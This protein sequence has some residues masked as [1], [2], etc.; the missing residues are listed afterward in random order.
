MYASDYDD[1]YP[2][3]KD[4]AD[5][6]CPQI[7]AS[8]PQW[9]AQ[10]P[11]MPRVKDVIQPYTKSREVLHCAA[12]TG[13]DHLEGTTYPIDA[14]PVAYHAVGN[15]Y[16]WRTEVAFAGT[17]PS[18][19]ARPAETNVMMD[20]NGG[21]HGGSSYMKGRWNVLYGDGHV[22]NINRTQLDEAWFTP[23]R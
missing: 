17:G 10:L 4:A 14:E 3:A 2:W 21:W 18:T 9:Q 16:H 1:R 6:Y 8:F 22:K 23:V 13:Y 12:D 7:W 20:A 5:A 11:F 15:S 19:L